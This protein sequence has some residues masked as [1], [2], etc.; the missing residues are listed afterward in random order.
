MCVLEKSVDGYGHN[1]GSF[2]VSGPLLRRYADSSRDRKV[3]VLGFRL[4]G[5]VLYDKDNDPY[6]GGVQVLNDDVRAN[7]EA[8]PLT[9]V[10]SING[11]ALGYAAEAVQANQLHNVKARPNAAVGYVKLVPKIDFQLNPN[12]SITLGSNL[13]ATQGS[14]FSR[15]LGLFSEDN[16]SQTKGFSALGYLRFT[17][18]SATAVLLKTILFLMPSIL[19]RQIIR[20]ITSPQGTKIT[21]KTPLIMDM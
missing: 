16:F 20:K 18:S 21:G 5:D 6:Y 9:V 17:Q 13:Y 7:L 12:V 14:N 4:S 1:Q 10:P 15:T 19:Y 8:H 11:P 3:P 2:T